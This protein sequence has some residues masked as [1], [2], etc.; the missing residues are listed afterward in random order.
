M[1]EEL[2]SVAQFV[3]AT[4]L[5]HLEVNRRLHKGQINGQKIGYFWAIRTSEVERVKKTG[6]YKARMR[7]LAA[8]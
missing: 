8:T 4:G 1:A 5:T 6:W 2:M 3:S 7:A